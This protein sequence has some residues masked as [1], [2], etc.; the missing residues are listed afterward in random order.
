[1]RGII[2]PP[3]EASSYSPPSEGSGVVSYR[4]VKRSCEQFTIR[5]MV[6]MC[7]LFTIFVFL[8]TSIFLDSNQK[9]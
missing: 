8:S 7:V 6:N 4:L 9:K 1:M 5:Q 3:S 2:P